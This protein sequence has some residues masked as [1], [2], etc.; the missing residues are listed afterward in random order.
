[1]INIKYDIETIN[2]KRITVKKLLFEKSNYI[3]SENF[4]K[5]SEN[6]LYI[7]YNL[8]DEIFLDSWFKKNFKGNIK[9]KLS[10]QLTRAAGNTT[11]KK[12]IAELRPEDVGFEVKISL[13]HLMNFSKIDR[14]KYVGGIEAQSV[15]DS[16]MLVL[17]HELC[18][19]IEF[20]VCHKSS[21]SKKPFKDLIYNLFG[22]T[23]SIHKLVTSNEVNAYEYG[24]KPGDNVKFQYNNKIINGFIQKINKRATIMSPDKQGNYA[25]KLGRRYRKFYVPL[26]CLIKL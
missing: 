26:E 13:N 6:D 20:I 8:Y 14:K 24:L 25:D 22:Q 18:H 7:L 4:N 15:L 21:C 11:T 10:R 23:E 3:D 12:N 5:I 9:F 19:V 1:M 16:L 2:D 17:E